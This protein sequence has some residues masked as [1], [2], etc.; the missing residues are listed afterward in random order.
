MEAERR[1]KRLPTLI[2]T[3]NHWD[4]AEPSAQLAVHQP[5]ENHPVLNGSL[6]PDS[7]KCVLHQPG[8][9][10]SLLEKRL[11]NDSYT[12][13]NII[14]MDPTACEREMQHA[15]QPS[16]TDG[17]AKAER[18]KVTWLCPHKSSEKRTWGFSNLNDSV[19]F[20]IAPSSIQALGL[21]FFIRPL[22][23]CFI[24][25]NPESHWRHEAENWLVKGISNQ[26]IQVWKLPPESSSPSL[27]VTG[28][29]VINH[30]NPG[31][32][33]EYPLCCIRQQ[34]DCRATHHSFSPMHNFLEPALLQ[35]NLLF[36]APQPHASAKQN[37][38]PHHDACNCL[39]LFLP[40]CPSWQ[41]EALSLDKMLPE[42]Q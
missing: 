37:A 16:V 13:L 12:S 25:N 32:F 5:I 23:T 19:G 20:C 40:L 2:L 10:D 17:Q 14:E 31:R 36:A 11:H 38:T 34:R 27:A 8:P 26:W 42:Y 29:R 21:F 33:T 22:R 4:P 18:K 30:L 28:T 6:V 41:R 7:Y 24:W 35:C 15:S 9:K 3:F 39:C 1:N